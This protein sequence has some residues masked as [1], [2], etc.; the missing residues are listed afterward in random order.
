MEALLARVSQFTASSLL[1]LEPTVT[2]GTQPS[3]MNGPWLAAGFPSLHQL[4]ARLSQS[5]SQT[6]KLGS[7]R[8]FSINCHFVPLAGLPPDGYLRR[9][10]LERGNKILID[11]PDRDDPMGDE[12]VMLGQ[13]SRKKGKGESK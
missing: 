4:H 13:I 10:Q 3:I 6:G 9:C 8:Y 5:C 2:S 11:H 7:W 12:V 1:Q